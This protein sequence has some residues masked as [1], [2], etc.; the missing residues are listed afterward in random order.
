MRRL[1]W[2]F[3]MQLGARNFHWWCIQ[4]SPYIIHSVLENFREGA[5]DVIFMPDFQWRCTELSHH[6]HSI[7]CKKVPSALLGG[8]QFCLEAA[9]D[10]MRSFKASPIHLFYGFRRLD[11]ISWNLRELCRAL[12]KDIFFIRLL[13]SD[14]PPGKRP[15]FS[16]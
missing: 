5:K 2:S 12:S 15:W 8:L 9:Q 10:A 13:W 14:Q 16:S 6:F 4:L 11:E 7:L 3:G 1:I